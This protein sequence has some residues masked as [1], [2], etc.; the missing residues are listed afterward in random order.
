MSNDRLH[1][2]VR[3]GTWHS[4]GRSPTTRWHTKLAKGRL[5]GGGSRAGNAALAQQLLAQLANDW[6]ADD[7]EEPE[8]H[9]LAAAAEGQG[10]CNARCECHRRLRLEKSCSEK[11]SA[12][13]SVLW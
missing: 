9:L 8:A 4:S 10:L 1:V 2:Q 7:D 5:K 13:R 12:D 3:H 11:S 6:D